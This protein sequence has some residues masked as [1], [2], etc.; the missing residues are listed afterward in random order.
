ML[1]S[2]GSRRV[3]HAG[4]ELNWGAF[5]NT[6][7]SE[8]VEFLRIRF[9]V[10]KAISPLHFQTRLHLHIQVLRAAQAGL[11]DRITDLSSNFEHHLLLPE[12]FTSASAVP[13]IHS[14]PPSYVLIAIPLI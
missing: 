11:K 8:L 14:R 9:D 6:A 3:G 10:P 13:L 4:T 5:V 12:A 2:M 1:Q 7:L